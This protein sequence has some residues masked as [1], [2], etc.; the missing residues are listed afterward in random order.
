MIKSGVT[1][2]AGHEVLI[3]VRGGLSVARQDLK[4]VSIVSFFLVFKFQN[5]SKKY[6]T[7]TNSLITFRKKGTAYSK[8]NHS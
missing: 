1:A 4:S 2:P 3:K 6:N 5:C 7:K 8:V